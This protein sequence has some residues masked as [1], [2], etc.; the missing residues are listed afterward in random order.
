[1]G[2]P[3]Q[4][5][6]SEEE[7]AL[8]A[9]VVKHGAGKWRTILK[10]PEFSS[11]LSLRSNVDLKDKWRNM[12]VTAHGWG[13]REKARMALKK[14][15]PISKQE[16]GP[17]ALSIVDD[18]DDEIVDGKPL[19]QAS[20][21]PLLTAPRKLVSKIDSLIFEAITNLKEPGGSN[22][23]AITMYIEDQYSAP[24]NL[25]KLLSGKLK[26]LTANGK[27][28]KVK[29]RY[30]IAQTSAQSEHRRTKSKALLPEGR[31]KESSRVDNK[32]DIKALSKPQID[33]EL[34]RMRNMTAEEAAVA[35]AQAVAEAEEAIAEAEEAA[36]DAEAA[37]ADAEAAEAFAEAAL[38]ALKK[39]AKSNFQF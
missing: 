7:S 11:V 1:M 4:K 5:W 32:K 3:K 22:K 24:P 6:T 18:H 9:G 21:L 13:S 30:R 28:S 19:A 27:L 34:A 31:Q 15:Q 39:R 16:E 26:A 25:K 20:P 35:A 2:A 29:R 8:K 36:R 38:K 12:S 23:T 10:D 37:E 14:S 33:A 17:L